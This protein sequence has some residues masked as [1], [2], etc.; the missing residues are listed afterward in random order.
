MTVQLV[1]SAFR[2]APEPLFG[3]APPLGVH[4]LGSDAGLARSRSTTACALLMIDGSLLLSSYRGRERLERGMIA[5]RPT[6]DART[7]RA[8]PGGAAW[9]QLPWITDCSFGASYKADDPDA[10]MLLAANDLQAAQAKLVR[11]AADTS[12]VPIAYLHWIDGLHRAIVA[13]PHIAI[14]DWARSN[15]VSREAAARSFRLAYD[16]R[17]SRF[18]LEIRA[19]TAWARIVGSSDPLSAIALESGFADQSHMT[20]AVGWFTGRSP[21]AWRRKDH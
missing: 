11:I 5:I 9:M 7:L 4:R 15:G 3:E 16:V 8:G 13:A 21:T 1:A 12:P 10:L 18:R 14:A 19:R 20:R 17:P 2:S 6:F